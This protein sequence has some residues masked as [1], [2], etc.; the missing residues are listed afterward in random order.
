MRKQQL[1]RI[2]NENDLE[3]EIAESINND[4]VNQVSD[5]ISIVDPRE[6]QTA[7]NNAPKDIQASINSVLEKI[8]YEEFAPLLQDTTS[9]QIVE[10]VKTDSL[11]NLEF[12]NDDIIFLRAKN[13]IQQGDFDTIIK[14]RR[15]TEK[16][17]TEKV[18]AQL[19]NLTDSNLVIKDNFKIL[20]S[21]FYEN[22]NKGMSLTDARNQSLRTFQVTL[23]ETFEADIINQERLIKKQEEKLQK[24]VNNLSEE[25]SDLQVIRL[26]NNITKAQRKLELS[27]SRIQEIREAGEQN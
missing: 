14:D 26:K 24:G 1:D 18:V 13:V 23:I 11:T 2:K 15:T 17:K 21:L 9:N 4:R 5:I 22:L 8:D 25:L 27:E 16:Y 6:R 3:D 10:I 19:K 12:S 20:L 7:I